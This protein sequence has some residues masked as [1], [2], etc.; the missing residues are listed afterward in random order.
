MARSTTRKR[1]KLAGDLAIRDPKPADRDNPIDK[2]RRGELTPK[3]AGVDAER[4]RGVGKSAAAPDPE[5]QLWQQHL[6]T[7]CQLPDLI[8]PDGPGSMPLYCAAQWIATRGGTLEIDPSD[9]SVWQDA[10]AQLLPRIASNEMTATGMRNS[11][12][13]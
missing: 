5:V 13:E 10:F 9:L 1:A 2:V 7:D 6:V 3:Q 4:R 11:Q 8:K 12:R